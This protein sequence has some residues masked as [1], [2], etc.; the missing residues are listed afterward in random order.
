MPKVKHAVATRRHK[1]R[2]LKAAEG[3]WGG[4]SRFYKR[5]KES[6]AK[7]MMY[8]Y[9]DRKAK[10]RN[11][12]SLWIARINAAC[13]ENGILYSRFIAG[14]NKINVLLDRKVLADI[15]VTDKKAFAKL[16]EAVKT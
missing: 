8:S 6:V 14:L 2:V 7:G 15:A 10:K 5:A 16:V 1:K 12:R 4:R 9:R 11:F 3:Q 13:R